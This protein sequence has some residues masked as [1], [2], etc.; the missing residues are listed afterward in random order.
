MRKFFNL[1]I[2]TVIL[3]SCSTSTHECPVQTN[4]SINGVNQTVKMGSQASV[5]VFHE[6]D[7][8]WNSGDYDLIKTFI[9]ADAKMS[10]CDGFTVVGPDDFINKIQKDAELR[11]EQE[12]KFE[13]TTD[14]VFSLAVTE[15]KD[16]N[17][18]V[19]D[20]V[21]AQITKTY[22]D[23]DSEQRIEVYRELFYIIDG[24]I[25]DW[26]QFKRIVLK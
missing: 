20:W 22:T 6:L 11:N 18:G 9:S 13:R 1:I 5:D 10:F 8:A 2:I 19:G 16:N 25:V 7:S 23:T 14:Y 24:Q 4:G 3:V 17:F 21:N 12:L 15:S 26:S